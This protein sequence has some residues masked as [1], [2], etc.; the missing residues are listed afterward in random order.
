MKVEKEVSFKKSAS[1]EVAGTLAVFQGTLRL[2]LI[3]P[4]NDYILPPLDGS[5]D[6]EMRE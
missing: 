3:Q 1:R 4:Y 6:T 2:S 5:S